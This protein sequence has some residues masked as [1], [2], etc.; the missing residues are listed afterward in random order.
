MV[1]GDVAAVAAI[2]ASTF[3]SWSRKQIVSEIQRNTGRSLVAVTSNGEVEA[4]CCGFQTGIDAELLK[5]TVSPLKQRLGIGE[6][7]LQELCTFFT[8]QG[9]EQMFLEVRSLNSPALNLYAK[10]GFQETGRRKQY[11][12]EP[13]DD[14]IIF[15]RRL[16]D[17][18]KE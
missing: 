12:K 13:A 9:A 4:W 18:D 14:A 10:L 1:V 6:V 7:L 17:N 2:E 15:V 5:I 8:K 11:Y 16:N 3:S